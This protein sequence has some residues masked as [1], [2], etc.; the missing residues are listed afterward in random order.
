M[1]A[2]TQLLRAIHDRS[3]G[4]AEGADEATVKKLNEAAAEAGR[5]QPRAGQV[6][7]PLAS[8]A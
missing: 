6:I 2:R 5:N 1:R 3:K 8:S 7:M 4:I